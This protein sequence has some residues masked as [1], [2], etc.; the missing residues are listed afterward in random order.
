[1][2]RRFLFL[3]SIFA[4]CAA[5]VSA[6]TSDANYPE[7]SLNPNYAADG[8]SVNAMTASPVGC[9]A[10]VVGL[11]YRVLP[12]HANTTATPTLAWCNG[13]AKTITKFGTQALTASD[14]TTTAVALLVWDSTDFELQ[15]PQTASS[16]G[17]VQDGA[18][19]TTSGE[20]CTSTGTAHVCSYNANDDVNS[21]GIFTT[22]DGITTA[23]LGFET[24]EG[25][26]DVT[27]QTASQS[28]VNLVSS[29]GAA[30]HYN[31]HIYLDQNAACSTGTGQVYATVNWTD[32]SHARQAT[33][34]P[35]TLQTSA[36][37]AYGFID[38]VIP[39]WSASGDAISY[40]TT[41][42]S[43]TTGTGSYDLHAYVE[44]AI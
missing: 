14:L 43:C 27:A 28:T 24:V 29:T 4:L 33:T 9:S 42:T 19:T 40:T 30:G 3:L 39:L 11:T 41:Y 31:V 23:G 32:A 20:I 12:G 22:Y 6:Q 17:T 15:N 21:G 10:P 18:G 7:G 1:M 37:S 44:R 13:S 16:A 5:A 35:L 25:T 26:S 36:S 2:T 8:G 38:A 34:V